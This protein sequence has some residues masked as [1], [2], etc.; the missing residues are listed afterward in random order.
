[1]G[2]RKYHESPDTSDLNDTLT[3]LSTYAHATLRLTL[4]PSV[5]S[6][7]LLLVRV[8]FHAPGV[9]LAADPV[10]V[11]QEAVDTR[12]KL[13]LAAVLHRIAWTAFESYHSTPWAWTGGMRRAHVRSEA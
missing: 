13:D 1:M 3:H 8:A 10:H 7:Y 2:K 12:R 11:Y 6:P 9:D 5:Q 4:W